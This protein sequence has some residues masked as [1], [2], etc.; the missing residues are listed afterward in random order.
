MPTSVTWQPRLLP[1]VRVCRAVAVFNLPA[2]WYCPSFSGT[3]PVKEMSGGVTRFSRASPMYAGGIH[4]IFCFFSFCLKERIEIPG[5][6]P[7]LGREWGFLS[8]QSSLSLTQRCGN[9]L[10]FLRGWVRVGSRAELW[11]SF[12]RFYP[13]AG[14]TVLDSSLPDDNL[15]FFPPKGLTLHLR[16]LASIL[17]SRGSDG[18]QGGMRS[19]VKCKLLDDNFFQWKF[20]RLFLGRVRMFPFQNSHFK[21]ATSRC[22]WH[23]K[24]Y[25]KAV[26]A[27]WL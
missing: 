22:S 13:W 11:F 17:G 14:S 24:D 18:A 19:S 27:N 8:Q 7:A 25:V 16:S 1:P 26:S 2:E 3:C 6:G 12:F 5:Q 23:Q 15:F 9:A 21:A 4:A 20:I 10:T